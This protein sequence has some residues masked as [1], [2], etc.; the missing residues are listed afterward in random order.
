MTAKC[1]VS[2]SYS[3]FITDNSQKRLYGNEM[4]LLNTEGTLKEKEVKETS[5]VP[6]DSG[7]MRSL[8]QRDCQV[9]SEL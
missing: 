1:L 4:C 3:L 8:K 5:G 2:I 6:A 7:K 9:F